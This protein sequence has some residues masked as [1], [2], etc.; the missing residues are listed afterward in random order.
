MLESFGPLGSALA[1]LALLLTGCSSGDDEPDCTPPDINGVPFASMGGTGMGQ[2]HGHGQLPSGVK[3]GQD[4]DVLVNNENGFGSSILPDN[5]FGNTTCGR[6]FSYRARELEPGTYRIGYNVY[7]D[8]LD[9]PLFEGNSTN[10]F[11]ITGTEDVEFN[12]TF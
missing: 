12:P 3:D 6:S 8:D 4:L 2:A 9:T 10:T 7:G 11:T 5:L 1:V